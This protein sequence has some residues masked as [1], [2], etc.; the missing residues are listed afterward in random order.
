MCV[1][2]SNPALLKK[3]KAEFYDFHV[4]CSIK[5]IVDVKQIPKQTAN[6]RK[7]TFCYVHTGYMSNKNV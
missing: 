3:I 2:V 7:I 4:I 6:N 1:C 5:T